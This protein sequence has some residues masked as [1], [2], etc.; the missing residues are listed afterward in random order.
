M[1]VSDSLYG[2]VLAGG[3][4]RR[5]GTDKAA[6]LSRGETQLGC[7]V[8]LLKSSLKKVYVSTNVAQSD[9]P[10]RRDFELIVDRYEDMGPL[11]GMLS[12]MDIFPTQSWLVLACDLPNLDEKTIECLLQN[13]SEV[14]PVTAFE[15]VV[16]GMPE[17]LCAIYRPAARPIIDI[18]VAQGIKCP[19]KI[20]L[21]SPTCLLTQPNPGALHNIN[22]PED[23]AGTS[24]ELTS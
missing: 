8:H 23:L 20:L 17:P 1:K 15:S 18:F 4:S 16:D 3:K 7:A 10:V 13:W 5:M 2:L 21:N 14:H 11:A 19:R 9:D 6:L 24:I 12:A 22:R